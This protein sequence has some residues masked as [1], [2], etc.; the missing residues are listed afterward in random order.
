MMR[1]LKAIKD[2]KKLKRVNILPIEITNGP[3]L[4]PIKKNSK[5]IQT[6]GKQ[7]KCVVFLLIPWII[8]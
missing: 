6:I 8:H 2:K 3:N 5:T 4:L 7:G 1:V